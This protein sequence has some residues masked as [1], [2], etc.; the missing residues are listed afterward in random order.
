MTIFANDG[1]KK[2]DKKEILAIFKQYQKHVF[3]QNAKAAKALFVTGNV[4]VTGVWQG[5][6][7]IHDANSRMNLYT[8]FDTPIDVEVLNSTFHSFD[9]IVITTGDYKTRVN[10]KVMYAGKNMW[11]FIKEKGDWK[12]SSIAYLPRG[13]ERYKPNFHAS[14]SD[15]KSCIIQL[16]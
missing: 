12:V 3:A 2:N 4:P 8:N 10:G 5:G 1:L 11:A 7:E 15:I 6:G 14:N 16:Y 13:V 9:N